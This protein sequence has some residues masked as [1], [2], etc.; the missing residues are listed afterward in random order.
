MVFLLLAACGPNL[1]A[2]NPY[3]RHLALENTSSVK[4]ITKALHDKDW[5]VAASACEVAIKKRIVGAAPVVARMVASQEYKDARLEYFLKLM[6]A[7]GERPDRGLLGAYLGHRRP[8]VRMQVAIALSP[9]KLGGPGAEPLLVGLLSDPDKR[10]RD[11]VLVV[12]EEYDSATA[13]VPLAIAK[14]KWVAALKLG[15]HGD[16]MVALR[17]APKK[18]GKTIIQAARSLGK[19]GRPVLVAVLNEQA[20]GALHMDAYVAMAQLG[21]DSPLQTYRRKTI[22]MWRVQRLMPLLVNCETKDWHKP[23][24]KI[25]AWVRR[26]PFDFLKPE[27]L[28]AK[29]ACRRAALRWVRQD[30]GKG[31]TE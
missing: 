7:L 1:K 3:E 5:R 2:E 22:E 13:R 29:A 9:K 16:V 31:N 19:L 11:Q 17:A 30:L 12:L 21:Q 4:A 26:P 18:N 27:L 24:G 28:R 20:L 10:V 6:G 14:G 8:S 25:R 15:A 23:M